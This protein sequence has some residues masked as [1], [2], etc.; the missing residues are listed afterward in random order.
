MA[1]SIPVLFLLFISA[2]SGVVML[3]L[4]HRAVHTPRGLLTLASPVLALLLIG[5]IR[6]VTQAPGIG[7]SPLLFAGLFLFSLTL[8]FQLHHE[9][10]EPGKR[11]REDA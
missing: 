7:E 8:L 9:V 2:A 6:L 1:Q 11:S 5:V 10:R 4:R 3:A